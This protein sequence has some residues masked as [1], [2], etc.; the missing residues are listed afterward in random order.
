MMLALPTAIDVPIY[1]DAHGAI[2][3]KNTRVLLYL[4]IRAFQRGETP[5]NIV[6]MYT[7]LALGDVYAVIAYYLENRVELDTYLAET[8]AKGAEIRQKLDDIQPQMRDI[9][10]RL[11]KRLEERR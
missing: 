3:I 10:E 6:Q 5:E 1:R 11:L 8:D 4:V 9:R 7:T 2:R